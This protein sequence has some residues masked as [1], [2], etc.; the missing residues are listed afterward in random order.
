MLCLFTLQFGENLPEN[1]CLWGNLISQALN[2]CL[3]LLHSLIQ[4]AGGTRRWGKG[5][6]KHLPKENLLARA[7]C[8]SCEAACKAGRLTDPPLSVQ[9]RRSVG[10]KRKLCNVIQHRSLCA[11]SFSADLCDEL[12]KNL[13]TGLEAGGPRVA[14]LA[15]GS[16]GPSTV[17]GTQ[18]PLLPGFERGHLSGPS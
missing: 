6:E 9:G 4:A 18:E 16:S 13:L 7:R 1:L 10:S 8:G 3:C 17:P 14:L 15:A 11:L 5:S 12:P 2:R